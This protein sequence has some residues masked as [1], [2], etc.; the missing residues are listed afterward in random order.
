MLKKVYGVILSGALMAVSSFVS[1]ATVDDV[2]TSLADARANLL[3]ML[4]S[5]DKATHESLKAKI[6]AAT[7]K[8]DSAVAELL[9]DKAMTPDKVEQLKAFKD[10]LEAFKKTRDEEIIPAIMGGK[11]DVAK[12]LA[13]GIQAERMKKMKAALSALG[14]KDPEAK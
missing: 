2:A 3:Q 8:V 12:D 9:A 14:W 7:K 13:K 1:A 11:M 4:N 5:T 10:T 6:D